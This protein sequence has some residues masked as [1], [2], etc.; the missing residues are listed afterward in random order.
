MSRQVREGTEGCGKEKKGG[1]P[2]G[3]KGVGTV[4]RGSG[5]GVKG[6]FDGWKLRLEGEGK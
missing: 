1:K 6:A 4:D 5:K 2:R 3:K